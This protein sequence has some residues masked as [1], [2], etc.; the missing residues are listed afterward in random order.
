MKTSI[1]LEI[2]EDKALTPYHLIQVRLLMSV[3]LSK[4]RS[5][6]T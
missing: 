4:E 3:A 2:F 5:R 6:S 1:S